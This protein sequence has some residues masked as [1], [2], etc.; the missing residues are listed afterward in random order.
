MRQAFLRER[1]MASR[2]AVRRLSVSRGQRNHLRLLLGDEGAVV[3][4]IDLRGDFHDGAGVS[5]EPDLMFGIGALDVHNPLDSLRV[6]GQLKLEYCSTADSAGSGRFRLGRTEHR[7]LGHGWQL[8][9]GQRMLRRG[10]LDD[11]CILVKRVQKREGGIEVPPPS[12]LELT[13]VTCR[14]HSKE[15]TVGCSRRCR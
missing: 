15:S 14:F 11:A 8:R 6:A 2:S 3:G 10:G 12:S 1:A 4:R 13:N 9:H 5:V 7:A